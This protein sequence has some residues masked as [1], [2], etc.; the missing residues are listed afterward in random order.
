[1]LLS[2]WLPI[3]L[4][5]VALFFAS[6]LSWMVLQLH[7]QDW[8]KLEHEDEFL[9]AAGKCNLT[10]GSYM[11]PGCKSQADMQSDEYKRKYEAGPRGVMTILPKVNMGQN[12]GLTFAYFLVVSALLGYLA[13]IAIKPGADFLHVFRFVSTAGLLTF[14]AAMVQHAI[15]FRPRIVGHVIESVAY[16]AITAAIFAALWPAK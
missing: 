7:K 14:L 16:A 5:A 8:K 2:L 3:V 1:M 10:E 11:F 13:T 9:A 4:S 12:L 15:W 6:F